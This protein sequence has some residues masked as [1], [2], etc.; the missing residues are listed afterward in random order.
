MN[1]EEELP[2]M[3]DDVMALLAGAR[4]IAAPPSEVRARLRARLAPQPIPPGGPGRPS[5]ATNLASWSKAPWWAVAAAL[6][7]GVGAGRLS[8]PA[9]KTIVQTIPVAV[10][11]EPP[12]SLPTAPTAAVTIASIPSAATSLAMNRAASNAV[13]AT[14]STGNLAAERR[15]LAVARTALGRSNGADALAACDEHERQFPKGELVE[16]REAIAI[17]ALVQSQ[18]AGEARERANRFRQAYPK[19]ILLPAVLASTEGER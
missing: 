9:P 10:R 2:P 4:T 11:S 3:P 6:L 19:S 15:L 7:V 1:G 12:A 14:K 18:R 13:V 8:A 16:E 5:Q 17:Q